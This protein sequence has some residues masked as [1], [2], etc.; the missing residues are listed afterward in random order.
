MKKVLVVY[1]LIVLLDEQNV[2]FQ[3]QS[4]Y[5]LIHLL[6]ILMHSLKRIIL[7]K[8]NQMQETLT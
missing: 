7:N 3:E 2:V 5:L 8:N 6:K 1:I 4:L